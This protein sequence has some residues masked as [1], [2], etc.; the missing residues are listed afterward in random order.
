[1]DL[2]Q[3]LSDDQTALLGCFLALAGSGLLMSLSYYIG[4]WNQSA[5]P[6][7][8]RLPQHRADERQKSKAA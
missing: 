7:T 1:M 5:K 8:H 3:N 2:L 4:Q 6:A